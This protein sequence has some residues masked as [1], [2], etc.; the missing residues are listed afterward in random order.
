LERG[1]PRVAEHPDV[2]QAV[3]LGVLV[4]ERVAEDADERHFFVRRRVV[5]FSPGDVRALGRLS[6]RESV[7]AAEDGQKLR[8]ASDGNR[9][10]AEE[11]LRGRGRRR[12]DRRGGDARL[13][14]RSLLRARDPRRE[15]RDLRE[16]E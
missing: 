15:G 11:R 16:Q 6:A 2:A 10:E 7:E 9:F 4:A 1:R 12:F 14:G 13:R 3:V 5:R 8:A